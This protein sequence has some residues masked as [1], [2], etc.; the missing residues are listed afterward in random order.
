MSAIGP[1]AKIEI[2][3]G[4]SAVEA[5]PDV[6]ETRPAPI[7]VGGKLACREQGES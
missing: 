6:A 3:S 7:H 4:K 5:R 2:A 1:K